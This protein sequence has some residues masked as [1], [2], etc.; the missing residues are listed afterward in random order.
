MPGMKRIGEQMAADFRP[1]KEDKF[2]FGLWTFG[3][4]G[5][6]P[7]GAATRANVDLDYAVSRLA[8]LGVWGLTFHDDDLFGFQPKDSYRKARLKLLS[9]LLREH[10]IVVPMVTTNLLSP[11]VF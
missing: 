5:S 2:S 7:F 10:Q 8:E 11:P 3:W 9:R 1:T 6:D 4:T